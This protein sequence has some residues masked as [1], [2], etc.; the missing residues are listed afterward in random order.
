MDTQRHAM[1][2][3]SSQQLTA[4]KHPCPTHYPVVNRKNKLQGPLIKHPVTK[5]MA[6]GAQNKTVRA[7]GRE[8]GTGATKNIR[9]PNI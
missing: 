2:L 1:F 3:P 6:A 5:N 4:Q 9:V 7:I 8:D